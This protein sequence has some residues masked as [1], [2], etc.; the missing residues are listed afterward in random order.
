LSWSLEILQL[1]KILIQTTTDR[2]QIMSQKPITTLAVATALRFASTS[3]A[4]FSE[5]NGPEKPC[6]YSGLIQLNQQIYY[7]GNRLQINL[8]I[9]EE[10][11][12]AL[13]N[14]AQ[15]HLA[16]HFPD[17]GF[18]AYPVVEE[19]P[20][21]EASVEASALAAGD[22]QLALVFTE[23]NGD[24]LVLADWITVLPG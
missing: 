11:K 20:F 16:V 2:S 22:Y 15:A 6:S 19:G 21:L 4:V 1:K 3:P 10:L 8:V 24:A 13:R 18:E 12:A 14:E 5:S 7:T 17:G 9:P 23:P